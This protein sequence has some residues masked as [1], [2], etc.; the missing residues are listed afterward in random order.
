MHCIQCG[1]KL[2]GTGR[3]CGHCGA[4]RSPSSVAGPGPVVPGSP[5]TVRESDPPLSSLP[6]SVAEGAASFSSTDPADGS[7]FLPGTLLGGRYRIGGLLGK[8]GMGEVYRADDL[9]LGQT[10]ALKFLPEALL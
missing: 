8:G 5:P 9:K 7:R 4:P 2:E 3:F 6:T 10:V 1:Q